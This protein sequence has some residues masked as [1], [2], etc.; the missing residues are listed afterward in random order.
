MNEIEKPDM[1]LEEAKQGLLDI[2]REN[3]FAALGAG[4]L[5]AIGA[6]IKGAAGSAAGGAVGGLVGHTLDRRAGGSLEEQDSIDPCDD[7]YPEEEETL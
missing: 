4:V 2:V 3:R 1:D 5:A 6:M 7:Q